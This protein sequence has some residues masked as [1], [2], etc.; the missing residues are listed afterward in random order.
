MVDL[1]SLSLWHDTLP[2][3]ETLAARPPL[4]SDIDVDV[5]IVGGGFTGLWTAHYLLAADP[6]LRVAVIEKQIAG[7]GASGRNGGWASALLPMTLD[8]IAKGHGRDAAIRMQRE[9]NASVDEVGRSARALAID[10]H[11]AKGGQIDLVRRKAQEPRARE[12]IESLARYGFDDLEWLSAKEAAERARATH[13]VGAVFNPNCAAIHPARLVRGLADAVTAAGGAL[14]EQTTVSSI[15]QG[16]VVTDHGVVR[17][18]IVVRATEGF[19][20][21]L[22]GERRTLVPIYSLMI[23]TEPLTDE[24]WAE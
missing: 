14:Y 15:E 18:D 7:F 2:Q 5:A 6:T 22:R 4:P 23:A 8:T 19:T 9:M 12:A 21:S 13:L 24:M 16:R 20:P 1:R 10:C 11:F 3:G 17:A